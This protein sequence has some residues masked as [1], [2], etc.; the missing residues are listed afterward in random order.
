MSAGHARTGAP[1]RSSPQHP[2]PRP[3][4]DTTLPPPAICCG[5]RLPFTT[6][7]RTSALGF[8]YCDQC[9][10]MRWFRSGL[11]VDHRAV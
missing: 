9:E 5:Q 3:A 7:E 2:A 11:P 4:A 6:V 10:S 8:T 1:R